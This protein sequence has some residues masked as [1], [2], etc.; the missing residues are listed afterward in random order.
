MLLKFER[1]RKRLRWSNKKLCDIKSV[2]LALNLYR[3]GIYGA[4]VYRMGRV[5]H[6]DYIHLEAI[7]KSNSLMKCHRN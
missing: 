1:N 6:I 4:G 7:S 3:G 5:P 2:L